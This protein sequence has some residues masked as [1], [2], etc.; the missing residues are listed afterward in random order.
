MVVRTWRQLPAW[1]ELARWKSCAKFGRTLRMGIAPKVDNWG[2]RRRRRRRRWRSIERVYRQSPSAAQGPVQD[3]RGLR[4]LRATVKIAFASTTIGG[5]CKEC[6]G[7]DNGK[8]KTVKQPEVA[9]Q[10]R[11]TFGRLMTIS[12]KSHALVTIFHDV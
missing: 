3:L 4:H 8:K 2:W 11:H 6:Q 1:I 12:Q 10:Q 5:R 9:V 7:T